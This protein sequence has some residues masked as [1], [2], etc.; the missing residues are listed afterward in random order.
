M[1]THDPL[2]EGEEAPPPGVRTMATL[3]WL[4]VAAMGVLATLS[5]LDY[6]EVLPRASV[7]AA[8]AVYYCPMHPSV[9]QDRPGECPICSMTLVLRDQRGGTDAA[10]VP[11]DVPGLVGVEL[12]PPRVQLAGIR[13]APVVR[14]ALA[15]TLDTVGFVEVPENARTMVHTRVAGWIE[16]LPVAQTGQRVEKGDVLATVYSPELLTAQ[17]ELLNARRWARETEGAAHALH[18]GPGGLV[19]DARTRLRL[20]GV[21]DDELGALERTGK[22]LRALPVRTPVGGYVVD[23]RAVAGLYVQPGTELFELADLSAVWVQAD[24]YES[25]LGRVRPGLAAHFRPA[26]AAGD[27]V[28]GRVTFLAPTIDARSRT[29]R[30]RIELPNPG[31]RLRPGAYGDVTIDVEP[32]PVLLVPR[33][34]VVDTGTLQY[35]F[36]ARDG[37]RFEPRRVRLGGRSGEGVAVLE[38]VDE[39]DVVVTDRKSV[40]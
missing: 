34:A 1:T 29:L 6:A 15:A 37:G 14:G 27:V 30:A 24:V 32:V 17:R 28:D 33:E 38:G 25:D 20:L 5:V 12:T 39:G 10:A 31:L 16:E 2:P 36:L 19:A 11:S 26:G 9:V 40:V 23:R 7:R 3:R 8:D 21:S 35:V 18:G 13:T 4:L 22:A